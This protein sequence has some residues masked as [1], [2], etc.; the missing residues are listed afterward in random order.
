M[1]HPPL[2][3]DDYNSSQLIRQSEGVI[4]LRITESGFN[5]LARIGVVLLVLSTSMVWIFCGIALPNAIGCGE[6]IFGGS[7]FEG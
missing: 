6:G 7:E 4:S 1:K 5:S 3:E 2:L